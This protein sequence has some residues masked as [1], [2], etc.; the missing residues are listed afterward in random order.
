M[1][2]VPLLSYAE[3]RSSTETFVASLRKALS[4]VGFF[5]LTDIDAVIPTWCEDWDKAFEVSGDF[6]ALPEEE[7]EAIAMIHSRHFRGFAGVGEEVTMGKKDLREQIDMGY[8][9]VL[10]WSWRF[11]G[12]WY[13]AVRR[14]R[15]LTSFLPPSPD[16][17]P[18]VPYPPTRDN[19]IEHSL[20]GPNLYPPTLPSF[21][22]AIKA[23]RAHCEGIA[24]DLIAAIAASLTPKPD[25]ITSLFEADEPGKPGYSR[26]KVVRYPGLVDGIEGLGCGAHKVWIGFPLRALLQAADVFFHFF[27]RTAEG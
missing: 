16:S 15:A 17:E 12:G 8:V 20:Y 5:V 27:E 22:P 14:G 13:G 23:Y 1:S 11:G 4:T 9:P 6:F 2:Y 3:A 26:L 10:F 18:I 19:P 21:A 24:K 7:K 25:L